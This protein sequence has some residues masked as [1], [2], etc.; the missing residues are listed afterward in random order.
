MD[1]E[2]P[3]PV[4]GPRPC[5]VQA[6][7]SEGDD[8]R[9][10]V[11]SR[12]PQVEVRVF[13]SLLTRECIYG[14]TA[15]DAGF[16]SVIGQPVK[17]VDRG[18]RR[19]DVSTHVPPACAVGMYAPV[20]HAST[21]DS[22]QTN[23]NRDTCQCH[24]AVSACVSAGAAQQ[25]SYRREGRVVPAGRPRETPTADCPAPSERRRSGL[26]LW[27]TVPQGLAFSWRGRQL[28]VHYARAA[29][30][31]ATAATTKALRTARS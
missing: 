25:A 22:A 28:G 29:A 5:A 23:R 9:L 19:H 6:T 4:P 21:V 30:T 10:E 31:A 15:T 8:Q 16:H 1:H 17:D 2:V 11:G 24:P 20:H 3:R 13:S 14:P 26:A 18:L 7:V 27:N 12:H